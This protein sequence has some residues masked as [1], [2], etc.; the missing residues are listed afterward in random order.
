[1]TEDER[2]LRTRLDKLANQALNDCDGHFLD[3]VVLVQK[4]NG[5]L[6]CVVRERIEAARL[7][8]GYQPGFN[9]VLNADRG[10]GKVVAIMYVDRDKNER[11]VIYQGGK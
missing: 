10:Q 5:I 2:R 7:W 1:M 9:E 3:P 11:C 4:R 6:R 8:P